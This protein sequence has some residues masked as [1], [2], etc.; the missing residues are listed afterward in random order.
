MMGGSVWLSG[1]TSSMNLYSGSDVGFA[2]H[3]PAKNTLEIDRS[4]IGVEARKNLFSTAIFLT[5]KCY[6]ITRL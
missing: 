5:A 2:K 6:A 3:K 4:T 1:G